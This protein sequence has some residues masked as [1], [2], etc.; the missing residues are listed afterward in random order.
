LFP[1]IVANSKTITMHKSPYPEME[2]MSRF[3]ILG[4]M[5]AT[6]LILLGVAKLA[7]YLG[8]MRL[9]SISFDWQHLLI[10]V[11]LGL[12]IVALSNLIYTIWPAY[13]ESADF[14]LVQVLKPLLWPDLIW[15]GL[16]PGLSEELLF[17]GVM[18]GGIGYD[19]LAVIIAAACFGLL[20]MN[21]I[22][23]WPYALWAGIVGVALG[24]SLLATDN[25]LVPIAAHIS[26][27]LCSASIWKWRNS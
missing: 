25:L 17:R 9:P 26:C 13:R 24:C 10:G 15:L 14:Y 7:L 23:Q 19:L 4:A 1:E 2:S 6:S 11:G 18:V 27:N 16:L 21:G 22:K 8:Q 20:H 12:V 5:G 3:E